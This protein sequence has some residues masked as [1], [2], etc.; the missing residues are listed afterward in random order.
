MECAFIVRQHALTLYLSL[1]LDGFTLLKEP[2]E[3]HLQLGKTSCI[4]GLKKKNKLTLDICK[5]MWRLFWFL[6]TTSFINN[7][8]RFKDSSEVVMYVFAG[9]SEEYKTLKSWLWFY[10][11]QRRRKK[12]VWL[13]L[14]ER[15]C[16]LYDTTEG[17][18]PTQCSSTQR[19]WEV[20]P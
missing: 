1:Q 15:F 19:F 12:T 9:D 5:T 14:L 4:Q 3:S 7:I 17:L 16:A 20:Q 2:I 18:Y 10:M 6:P 13:R 11:L 8:Y